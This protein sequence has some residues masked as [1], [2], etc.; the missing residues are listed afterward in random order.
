MDQANSC[1]NNLGGA[2]GWFSL[3]DLTPPNLLFHVYPAKNASKNSSQREIP[4]S[5]A[6]VSG[7]S[8]AE[9]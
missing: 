1:R 7:L 4:E 2:Q 9:L 5:G 8:N 6:D 3:R